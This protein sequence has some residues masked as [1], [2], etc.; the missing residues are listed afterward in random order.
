MKAARLRAAAAA[1]GGEATGAAA[2]WE[3]AMADQR[4]LET[5]A[6]SMEALGIW[7]V[8]YIKAHIILAESIYV[9]VTEFMHTFRSIEAQF[10]HTRRAR[11]EHLASD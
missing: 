4:S 5:Y 8:R 9:S 6:A 11:A 2:A 3:A 7:F 10:R 1:A